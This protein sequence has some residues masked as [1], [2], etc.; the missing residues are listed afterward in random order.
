M[1][2]PTRATTNLC[3]TLVE[4]ILN[5]HV[6]EYGLHLPQ[7]LHLGLRMRL[8]GA[9]FDEGSYVSD[10]SWVTLVVRKPPVQNLGL[11]PEFSQIATKAP[12][13]NVAVRMST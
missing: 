4:P 9:V 12:G 13:I 8:R 1:K 10:D 11:V 7:I 5:A 6:R 2:D 3:L